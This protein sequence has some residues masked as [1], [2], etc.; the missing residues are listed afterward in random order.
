MMETFLCFESKGAFF[1]I[2]LK[3]VRHIVQGN[4]GQEQTIVF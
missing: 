1:L 4:A 2:P 3:L